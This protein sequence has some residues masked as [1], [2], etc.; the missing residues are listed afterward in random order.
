MKFNDGATK[1]PALP[2]DETATND[3]IILLNITSLLR[4]A[5]RS[6]VLSLNGTTFET[7]TELHCALF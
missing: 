2:T 3:K 1:L 6:F 4:L 5:H 7:E